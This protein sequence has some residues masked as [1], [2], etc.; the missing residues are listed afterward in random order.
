MT[1]VVK[2]K[3]YALGKPLRPLRP[4]GALSGGSNR[5]RLDP[6]QFDLRAYALTLRKLA[7]TPTSLGLSP[8]DR[9]TDRTVAFDTP[10]SRRRRR[11]A[12]LAKN[13]AIRLESPE[14]APWRQL[15]GA[16]Q[17]RQGP[18]RQYFRKTGNLNR[19]KTCTAEPFGDLNLILSNPLLT[20][21]GIISQIL[22]RKSQIT[23]CSHN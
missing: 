8:P 22:P 5:R 19:I 4:K 23:I 1:H 7:A 12:C 6:D 21:N 18:A 17:R 15:P 3:V 10:H 9:S 14:A 2:I 16:Q 20:K 13:Q 11:F